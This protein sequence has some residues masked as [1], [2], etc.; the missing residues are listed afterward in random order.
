MLVDG[1]PPASKARGQRML[2]STV[3][4]ARRGDE[5]AFGAL[6]REVGDRCIFIAH[7]ILRDAPLAEAWLQQPDWDWRSVRA[8]DPQRRPRAGRAGT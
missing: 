6:V 3:D 4:Q 8:P 2:R 7:R 5:E 1:A